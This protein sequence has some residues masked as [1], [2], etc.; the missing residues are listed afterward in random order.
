MAVIVGYHLQ[1]CASS[2]FAVKCVQNEG[3]SEEHARH[4]SG[5]LLATYTGDNLSTNTRKTGSEQQCI[6]RST[7]ISF[8]MSYAC[9]TVQSEQAVAV[10]QSTA[11]RAWPSQCRRLCC[12]CRLLL[13]ASRS[14][15]RW[16]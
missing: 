16:S 7:H 9:V 15:L 12:R 13:Y 2:Y 4:R 14:V 3:I 6:F 8:K 5:R 11:A 10:V 1:R